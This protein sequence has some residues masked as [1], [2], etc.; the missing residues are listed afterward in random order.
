MEQLTIFV[1]LLLVAML[2]GAAC[3]Q[4]L[5]AL[6]GSGIHRFR[7]VGVSK[8][9]KQHGAWMNVAAIS[10]HLSD[11]LQSSQAK[12]KLAG[13]MWISLVAGTIGVLIGSLYFA[14]WQGIVVLGSIMTGI[15]YLTLRSK[16]ISRQMS[17]RMELL[18][19]VELLYQAY[20]LSTGNN[21]RAALQ[22][23][24]QGGRMPQGVA[25]IF[26]QLHVGLMMRR[27][28]EECIRIF[29]LALGSRWADH[30]AE[31]LRYALDDGANIAVGLQE[32][33]TDMRRAI[34][35]DQAERNRL[36]EIRI[37][38]FSP[39]LFLFL[40]I[41]VNYRL[42]PEQAYFYY[43]VSAEGKKMLL[44]SLVLIAGSFMMGL[45]LSLRKI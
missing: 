39:L 5:I 22:A 28:S 14:S 7:V 12:L 26:E 13:F 42:H 6:F 36:L 38:N 10:R 27:G 17:H 23:V 37:A 44:D 43:V 45:Y 15:P 9:R 34:R 30:L 2:V 11:L 16:L 4:L 3:Y 40:F 20:L 33:I 32:L 19:A 8:R 35:S 24:V 25:P 29:A 41:A 31:L 18:P 21:I 1:S